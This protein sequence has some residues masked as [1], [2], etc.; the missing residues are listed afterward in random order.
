[1]P[2]ECRREIIAVVS[3]ECRTRR[4][5]VRENHARSAKDVVFERHAFVDRHIVLNLH[6]IAD[7]DAAG[8]KH[9][10]SQPTLYSE[11]RTGH[12]VREMPNLGLGADLSPLIDDRGFVGEEVSHFHAALLR[13]SIG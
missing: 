3:R 8:H 9:V 7:R 6:V 12:D 2:D 11:P 1:M 5:D 4:A 10:L 13:V